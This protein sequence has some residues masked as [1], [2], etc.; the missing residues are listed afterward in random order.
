MKS[1][2]YASRK[3]VLYQALEEIKRKFTED[4][5]L[6]DFDFMF[7][8]LNYKYPYEH[9]DRDIKRVFDVNGKDYVAF[10]ATEAIA[11]TDIFE[12]IAVCFIKFENR[13]KVNVYADEG[14]K[15]YTKN[16]TITKLIDY[17]EE[18]KNNLNIFISSWEDESLGLFIEDLGR[19][20]S[21]RN[22]Y[23]NLVG[24]VSSGRRYNNELRTF[25][26]YDGKI[27]KNGFVVVTFEN[28]EF[29]MGISSGFKP[30]SPVYTVSRA[31]G[32]KIYEVDGKTPFKEIVERFLKGLEK[33]VEYLWYCPIVILEDEE[34][35][36]R[37]Q[38]TFKEIGE[39]YV[40]FFAPVYEGGK[41]MLSF[42]TPEQIIE[43]TKKEVEKVKR[44]IECPELILNFSCI[45]RQY[46]LEN[47]KEE[48]NKVIAGELDAPLFGFATYGEV[49]PDRFFKKVKLY[50]E[51]A[52][53]VALKEA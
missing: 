1:I 7:I 24:G 48:E 50:N 14:I 17:L 43:N 9:L 19:L 41:F 33:K 16:G 34:G 12:G 23:P 53:F 10:H 39:D 29:S 30:I 46:V 20:L 3:P 36:V 4:R 5:I 2:V 28:V 18:N 40:E 22:F 35:Y 26:F 8:A 52:T 38:R 21:S 32:Y 45:A 31:E 44:N 13:G 47:M 11:N 27:I 6:S 25:Q 51:T 15:N 37:I 49:G 42:G